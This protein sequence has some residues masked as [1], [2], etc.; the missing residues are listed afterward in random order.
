VCVCVCVC[1]CMWVRVARARGE[2]RGAYVGMDIVGSDMAIWLSWRW[3]E[4]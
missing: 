4:R 3:T 1:V 2:R